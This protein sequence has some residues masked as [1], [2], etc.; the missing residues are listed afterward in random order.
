MCG[1]VRESQREGQRQTETDRRKC[2]NGDRERERAP[3]ELLALRNSAASSSAEPPIS[4]I[5]MI[6]SVAGSSK[7]TERQ[8]MKSVPLNGSPPIPTAPNVSTRRHS[9]A[10]GG[11]ASSPMQRDWPRPTAVV[12]PTASYVRVPERETTP[13]KRERERETR[14]STDGSTSPLT[15]TEQQ[16][17]NLPLL[18]NVSRHDPDLA[19]LWCDDPRAIGANEPRLV[20][21]Q[22]RRL[23]LHHVL[24]TRSN[25]VS[26]W[27]FRTQT[28]D[29]LQI[30]V[31]A[32]APQTTQMRRYVR[33]GATNATGRSQSQAH[34]HSN[35]TFAP[36][37]ARRGATTATGRWLTP[38]TSTA[39]Q[40]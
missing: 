22:Q 3:T 33:R 28:H 16:R 4:P 40:L 36:D 38:I 15:D 39:P 21:R 13:V 10:K 14:E 17:T 20:L 18:V 19:G 25:P 37:G 31:H 1:R 35:H 32:F 24:Q 29:I 23:D 5:M 12:C 34:V 30:R 27:S 8:S 11:E 7:K 6:P 26:F 2:R 9:T